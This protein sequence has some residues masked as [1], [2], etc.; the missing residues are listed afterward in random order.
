VAEEGLRKEMLKS[1]QMLIYSPPGWGAGCRT[2]DGKGPVPETEQGP[3]VWCL[4]C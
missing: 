2:L 3:C 4:L 1:A